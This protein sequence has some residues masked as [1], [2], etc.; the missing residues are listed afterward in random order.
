MGKT[1]NFNGQPIFNQ[2]I[3]FIDKSEIRKIAKEHGSERYVKKFTTYNHVIVML[4]VAFE[5]YH[6]IREVIL[7][8]LAN[9]HKLSHLGLSYL[10]RRSTFSEANQRRSSKVFGD[11]YLSVYHKHVSDLADSRLSDADMRR[12]YIMDSTTI[13]LFK[14]ILRGVGR[15]PKEGKK[16]GGIKAHTIIKASENVPCLIRYSEAARHDHMFLDEV[17]TLASGSI[18]TFDKGYVDYAQY[19]AFTQNSIWYVTRLK[20]N[21]VYNAKEEFD[22]PDDA[23]TGVLKDEEIIL[24]YGDNKEQQHRARR[25]AY[26]DNDNNRLFEFISNNF[27]LP[28]EKIALIYKKRWQIELLFKQLKQNFPLKY[29]LGDNENAIEIQIWS[30]MLANLLITL[31]RSKV[32]RSWAFSNLV[33]L[34]RQQLMNYINIYHFLEDPEGSWRQ[35]VKENKKKYENSLFPEIQGAYF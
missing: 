22:I 34:I 32:K 21:A 5:G 18:I 35:I 1:T 10:V 11:I 6:S 12:L 28:A 25:I 27:E 9:A 3:K 19:E 13:S 33:S 2:L 30:A 4:F 24:Y 29:F 14:D 23:D 31:V 20:E 15:N 26:W 7:G 8:L 17:L 16:K